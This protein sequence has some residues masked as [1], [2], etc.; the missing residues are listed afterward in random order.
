MHC[1]VLCAVLCVWMNK[2]ECECD[3][4]LKK[5]EA[6]YSCTYGLLFVDSRT[7]RHIY[8]LYIRRASRRQSKPNIYTRWWWFYM[9][10]SSKSKLS[11]PASTNCTV[12]KCTLVYSKSQSAGSCLPECLEVLCALWK[13]IHHSWICVLTHHMCFLLGRAGP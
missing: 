11:P 1:A 8:F 6:I 2:T 4:T 7:H 10:A 5:I 9:L 13:R 3:W 12:A